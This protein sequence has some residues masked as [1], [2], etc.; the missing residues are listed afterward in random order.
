VL[1]VEW[2]DHG[3]TLGAVA[4]FVRSG[5]KVNAKKTTLKIY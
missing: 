5:L 2:N 4:I 3:A 1:A